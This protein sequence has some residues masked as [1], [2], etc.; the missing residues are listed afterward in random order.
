MR[1]GR[2]GE[3]LRGWGAYEEEE[4]LMQGVDGQM[5]QA[6]GKRLPILQNHLISFQLRLFRDRST[7]RQTDSETAQG[8]ARCS[9]PQRVEGGCLLKRKQ[10]CMQ[11]GDTLR[12]RRSETSPEISASSSAEASTGCT[13]SV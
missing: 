10:E 7:G 9:E 11:E 6:V 1:R 5:L 12:T 3:P 8:M 13:T 2:E 4:M